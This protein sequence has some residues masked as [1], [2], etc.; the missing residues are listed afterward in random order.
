MKQKVIV[1]AAAV[2]AA[3]GV[4]AI[5]AAQ[6]HVAQDKGR[7][8]SGPF[9][10]GK[11]NAGKNAGVVRSIAKTQKCRSYELRKYGVAIADN[12]DSPVG[13]AAGVSGA[14]GPQGPKGATGATGPAG[15]QGPKGDTGATG[16]QG[17]KGDTG[18][19]GPA[20]PKGEAGTAGETGPAGPQGP[21][22][23]TGATGAA[24]PAGPSGPAGPKGDAGATG[25]AGPAGPQGPK[26]DTGPAGPQGPAGTDGLGNGT[27]EVCVSNGG[28]LQLDVH[29]KPCDN[30]GHQPI[31]LVV[32][33]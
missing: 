30:E 2:M 32:V 33:N 22:G 20:G 14:T 31:T 16:A 21:K 26:G 4:V 18:A 12:D 17:P 24:G 25:A 9:C 1:L 8:L 19:T 29:G 10:V 23:D 11:P 3:L 7:R 5:S 6:S 13:V 27:I 15:S 28:T